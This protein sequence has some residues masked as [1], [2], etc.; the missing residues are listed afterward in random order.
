MTPPIWTSRS[1][2]LA[3][4][5]RLALVLL[6][7]GMIGLAQPGILRPDGFG[8]LAFF[9]IGPWAFAASR[10]GRR[11]FLAEWLG[12]SLGLAI[13]FHWMIA[14][15]PVILAP[16][17]IVP[18]LYPAFAGVLLRRC[19]R[20]PL[21][22]LAPA[23]WLFAEALRWYLPVPF[24]FGWFRLGMLM[25]DTEWIVGSAA[26]LGTWGLSWGIAALGGLAAD[27]YTAV[28][29]PQGTRYPTVAA[30]VFGLAPLLGLIGLSVVADR[31]LQMSATGSDRFE[32]GP[33]LLIVQPGISQEIKAARRDP[34]AD[35]FVPQVTR[36]L[37]ALYETRPADRSGDDAQPDLV[38]WGETFLPGK[39]SSPEVQ[40][41]FREGARPADWAWPYPAP[42]DERNFMGQ[43][44][45]A[46]EM[47]GALFG[48][49]SMRAL[50]K[51]LFDGGLAVDWAER[52]MIGQ[53]LLPPGTSFLSGVEAW[54]TVGEGAERELR[55]VN[56]VVLWD[57]MGQG[58]GVASKVHIVPGGETG[59]PLRAVPFVLDAV[60]KVARAI[61]DFVGTDEPSVLTL[62]TRDGG[63]YRMGI[64]VCFDN[65]FD[66]PFTAPLARGPVDFFVV[67]SNEAWYD[68][69]ALMDHMLA[70][71]RI[72][73]A[74]TQRS[75]VRATNSGISC[76]VG[77]DGRVRAILTVPGDD[78]EADRKRKMVAGVLRSRVP[79][80]R[81][82]AGVEAAPAT[83]FVHAERWLGPSMGGFGLALL[84]LGGLLGA[85]SRG[86]V[87]KSKE[88]GYPAA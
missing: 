48:Q 20:W 34:L 65:A 23:A 39:L 14:F 8:H 57:A 42:L 37:Q 66:D 88:D 46:R 56:G 2:P 64:A 81:R 24:S 47:V 75:I 18:A 35:R 29:R 25:H 62:L 40:S 61:P 3:P 71:T 10:P 69:S 16:M 77:P 30:L 4:L 5:R 19:R 44:A 85:A 41:A 70:F 38:L 6:T 21:A 72:A 54:T 80:P 53:R 59:E 11:A 52:V 63:A 60:K 43:D 26:W 55:S 79:V 74:S 15:M 84:L 31:S 73:A 76:V 78:P 12:H 36:T 58:S 17:S 7:W 1:T 67:A 13:V 27:L 33:D 49:A 32:E 50:W 82:S 22:L 86:I 28:T 45:S 51:G 68:D 83:F 87:V 9:A